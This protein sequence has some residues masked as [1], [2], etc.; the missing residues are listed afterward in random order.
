MN[1]R[2]RKAALFI[3]GVTVGAALTLFLAPAFSN[4]QSRITT[5]SIQKPAVT[6][7]G[8]LNTAKI[9]PADVLGTGVVN[10]APLT[11]DGSN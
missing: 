2:S 5:G 8:D 6:A 7:G 4:S 10:W 1:D 9:V 11:G 3:S